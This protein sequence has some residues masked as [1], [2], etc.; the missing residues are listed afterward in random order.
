MGVYDKLISGIRHPRLST[1]LYLIMGWSV[2]IVI[3]P[4]VL[5][6]PPSGMGWL[7]AGGLAYTVGVVFYTA[8]NLPYHHLIWHL[9]V[10]TGT[11]CHFFAVL[12]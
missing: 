2:V 6:M 3:R 12:W 5:S 9:F 4:L 11:T 10:L 8:R 1:A 7:V